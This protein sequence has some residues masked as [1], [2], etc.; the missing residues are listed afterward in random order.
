MVGMRRRSIAL[1][2]ALSTLVAG[3]LAAFVV[4]QPVASAS[5]A[6]ALSRPARTGVQAVAYNLGDTVFRPGDA[7]PTELA[8]IVHY[9]AD[10]ATG[11]HPLI[12]QL[13]GSWWSCDDRAAW[14]KALAAPD[15]NAYF[16]AVQPMGAWPCRDGTPPLPSSRGYDY[17]GEALA[18]QGFVVVSIGANGINSHEGTR[19]YE[20]RAALVNRHLAM[21]QRLA[22]GG[23]GELRNAFVDPATGEPKNVPFT[24]H[25]DMG[26]VGTM[27]HSRGGKGVMWQ[28]ADK[29]RAEWPAG[30]KI[31]AVMPY[32]SVYFNIPPGDAENSDGLVTTMPI[33]VVAGTC[34]GA[35]ETVGLSYIDDAKGRNRSGMYGFTIHGAN[36]NFFNTAWS[37]SSG[38]AGAVD[39]AADDRL[40]PAG[41][42]A[43]PPSP[44][45]TA[46]P[47]GDDRRLTED[48]QRTI[49][50]T[51]VV[52][53]F[54]RALLGD[55]TVDPI[56]TGAT[57]PHADITKV[58]VVAIPPD[59]AG[60]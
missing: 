34:D 56:L 28:A 35:V 39:D 31:K 59:A 36:H 12:M 37:P 30:V 29:H 23:T 15:D 27:G 41:C 47:S 52:A 22:A 24:G 7:G 44:K 6:V 18:R 57:S 13:H 58:D 46:D 8:G 2:A 38:N 43:T 42:S 1:V 54:R 32:A 60:R 10:L 26:N 20:A 45:G 4:T 51:Y 50:T 25:V 5:D 9:P 14:A 19:G 16:E 49:G 17:L 21:W 40:R 11:S 33:G 53:F 3:S 48:E 55:A